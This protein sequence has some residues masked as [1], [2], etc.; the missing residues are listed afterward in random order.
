M[1]F[2]VNDFRFRVAFRVAL[3]GLTMSLLVYMAAHHSFTFLL[4]KYGEPAL[5]RLM[6]AMAAG[7][8]FPAAFEEVLGITAAAFAEEFRV[9][10]RRTP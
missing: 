1:A 2:G 8:T 7:R 5:L 10:V 6:D 3:I 9:Y 4:E